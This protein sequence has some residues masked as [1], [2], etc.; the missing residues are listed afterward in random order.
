MSEIYQLPDT[1]VARL[2]DSFVIEIR[3]CDAVAD[4]F[5]ARL[6]SGLKLPWRIHPLRLNLQLVSKT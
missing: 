6:W 5:V 3:H 2:F 4:V 1:R